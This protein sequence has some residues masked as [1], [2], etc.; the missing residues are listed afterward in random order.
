MEYLKLTAQSVTE[1]VISCVSSWSFIGYCLANVVFF[2]I[3]KY[4]GL[5]DIRRGNANQKCQES[6]FAFTRDDI[7][8]MHVVWCFPFYATFLPRFIITALFVMIAG[9]TGDLLIMS[10]ED[11]KNTT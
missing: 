4:Y 5:R 3:V 10:K 1:N 7:S 6:Y 8:K 2:L 9:L 11:A